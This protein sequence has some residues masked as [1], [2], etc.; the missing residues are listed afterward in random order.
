[1]TRNSLGICLSI[2]PPLSLSLSVSFRPSLSLKLYLYI[3]CIVSK[4]YICGGS[5]DV[6]ASRCSPRCHK[7]FQ[8]LRIRSAYA[9]KLLFY[10]HRGQ[11]RGFCPK[12]R[13][14]RGERIEAE[15]HLGGCWLFN[16]HFSQRG[17]WLRFS[18]PSTRL[19]EH[20]LIDLSGDAPEDA[21]RENIIA[22]KSEIF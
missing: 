10:E 17:L 19:R 3:L 9:H 20:K 11:W 21:V 22:F 12:N 15:A 16:L 4:I 5:L 1:M 6:A 2:S 14:G 18:L 7:H 13:V 8:T